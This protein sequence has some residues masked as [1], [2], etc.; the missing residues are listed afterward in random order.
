MPSWRLQPCACLNC[1][2]KLDS[3][4]NHEHKPGPGDITICTYCHHIMVFDDN[5]N[6]RELNDEE[7]VDLAGDKELLAGMKIVD[8]FNEWKKER[9]KE[10]NE[11]NRHKQ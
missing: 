8:M 9:E 7:I 5:L 6:F 4:Y 10:E 1:G 11:R 3:A 2:K